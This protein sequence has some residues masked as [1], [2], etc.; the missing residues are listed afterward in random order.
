M[1]GRTMF[2]TFER[3]K[4]RRRAV[5]KMVEWIDLLYAYQELSQSLLVGEVPAW[6]A[7]GSHAKRKLTDA[8]PTSQSG[9]PYS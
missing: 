3:F 7:P 1:H 6:V 5:A 9:S 4:K 8:M 2:P